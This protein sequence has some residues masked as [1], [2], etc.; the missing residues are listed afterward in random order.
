MGWYNG[1]RLRRSV[2][3]GLGGAALAGVVGSAGAALRLVDGPTANVVEV[4]GA[5]G[6]FLGLVVGV[7]VGYLPIAWTPRDPAS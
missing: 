4:A 2:G 5:T 3:H 6:G 7:S 1:E